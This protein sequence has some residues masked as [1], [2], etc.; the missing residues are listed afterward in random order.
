VAQ[1]KTRMEKVGDIA[2]IPGLRGRA[3]NQRLSEEK[4][5]AGGSSPGR[6]IAGSELRWPAG[7]WRRSTESAPD[8]TLCGNLCGKP[9]CGAV[10]SSGSK[11]CTNGGGGF[12]R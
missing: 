5:E 2:V 6:Y 9:G 8:Q 11:R 12:T 3:S 10:G 4:R 1:K 7:I